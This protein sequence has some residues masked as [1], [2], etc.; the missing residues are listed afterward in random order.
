MWSVGC[1]V[2]FM[3]CKASPFSAKTAEEVDRLASEA[4]FAFPEDV[5]ISAEGNSLFDNSNL[6][7][8]IICK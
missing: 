3:L 2:Y 7:S 1:I 5:F 4:A 6:V 8:K